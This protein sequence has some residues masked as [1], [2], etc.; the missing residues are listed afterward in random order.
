MVLLVV[1][2]A[3]FVVGMMVTAKS[4]HTRMETYRQNAPIFAED[5]VGRLQMRLQLTDEQAVQVRKI[6]ERRH[7]QM[8]SHRQQGSQAIHTEFNAMVAEVE[9][10]LDA[11]QAKQWHFISEQVRQRFLPSVPPE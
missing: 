10:A 8:I 3:G 9:D 7:A 6:I 2:G 5:I 4:I 1:F 11:N